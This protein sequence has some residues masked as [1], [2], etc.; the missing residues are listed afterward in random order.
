MSSSPASPPIAPAVS[1][2]QNFPQRAHQLVSTANQLLPVRPYLTPPQSQ[3]TKFPE[4]PLQPTALFRR[5]VDQSSCTATDLGS[6]INKP[7]RKSGL[8]GYKVRANCADT[9][10]SKS[11]G[12]ILEEC[13]LI[14]S[15]QFPVASLSRHS[16]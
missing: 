5:A 12:E 14:A 3:A 2:H 13:L 10:R 4:V 8:Y 7:I 11:N 6:S 1:L 9:I 15:D 16:P